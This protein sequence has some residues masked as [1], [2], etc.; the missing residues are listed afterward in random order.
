[1]RRHCANG[2]RKL[3]A[4]P[5]MRLSDD[6]LPPIECIVAA[7]T[8]RRTGTFSGAAAELNTTHA[9]ISRRV[10]TAE[11]WCGHRLFERQ[12]RGVRVTSEGER[13]VRRLQTV[14]EQLLL[15]SEQR[16]PRSTLPVV[17]LATTPSFARFWLLPRLLRLQG[18]PQDLHIAIHA[19]LRLADLTAGEVDLALRYG[20][21]GWGDG[22]EYVLSDEYLVPVMSKDRENRSDSVHAL[23]A[24]PLLHAGDLHHWRTWGRAYGLNLELKAADRRLIDYAMTIDAAHAGIGVALWNPAMHELPTGLQ[25]FPQ[26]TVPAELRYHLVVRRGDTVSPAAEL[27]YRIRHLTHT[28]KM[29]R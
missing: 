14:L 2:L 26:W 25:S 7:V 27:A 22:E 20:R 10:A 11:A 1:M 29:P 9:T 15:V 13:I 4:P 6:Q 16:L 5:V 19:D 3:Y 28:D 24:K 23:A 8:A 17:R 12:A 18:E 21:G